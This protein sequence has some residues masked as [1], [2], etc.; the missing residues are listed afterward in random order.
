MKSILLVVVLIAAI[1]ASAC[2]VPDDSSTET[3]T[4]TTPTPALTTPT[5]TTTPE[6]PPAMAAAVPRGELPESF[7]L[8]AVLDKNTE[9]VDMIEE[10]AAMVSGSLDVGEIVDAVQGIY[11]AEGEHT[12][13]A[14]TVIECTDSVNAANAV[15]NYKNQPKFENPPART[16]SRFA[17][18]NFNGHEANEVR[19]APPTEDGDIRYG[20]F[21]SNGNFVVIVEP[22]TSDKSASMEL[23]RMTGY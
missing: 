2:I 14:V 8:R 3:P 16:V 20:Y 19:T 9:T 10:A 15:R 22:G 6:T 17:T 7:T 13:T 1:A 11:A 12:D 23:A 21:W 5:A 18:A 4:P